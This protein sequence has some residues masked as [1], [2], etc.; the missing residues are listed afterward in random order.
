MNWCFAY[1]RDVPRHLALLACGALSLSLV[2]C[3]STAPRASQSSGATEGCHGDVPRVELA[4]SD[5][6]PIPVVHIPQGG[7]V[8]VTVPT[9]PFRD[10]RTEAPRVTPP[11]RLRMLSE[12]FN[13]DGTRTVYYAAER[14]G[15]AT[16][17]STV[18]V[19]SSAAIPAWVGIVLIT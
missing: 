16:I 3:S 2:A 4:I 19:R 18:K 15:T 17:S 11:V 14:S 9:S 5:T 12:L 6:Q 7:C 13:R 10:S 1:A 8:E